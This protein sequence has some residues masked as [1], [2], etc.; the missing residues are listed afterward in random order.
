MGESLCIPVS[1]ISSPRSHLRSPRG[2]RMCIFTRARSRMSHRASDKTPKKRSRNG[3]VR[4]A[5]PGATRRR[6]YCFAH[7]YSRACAAHVFA[8]VARTRALT[9]ARRGDIVLLSHKFL[10]FKTWRSHDPARSAIHFIHLVS[11]FTILIHVVSFMAAIPYRR[12]RLNRAGSPRLLLPRPPS[13]RRPPTR[14]T[15]AGTVDVREAIQ[16]RVAAREP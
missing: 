12:T 15:K 7:I 4:R 10:A 1:S 5:R 16:R 8:C 3:T 14:Q 9:R 13:S 2:S 6:A 11:D